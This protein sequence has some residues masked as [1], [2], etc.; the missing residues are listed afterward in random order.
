ME[1]FK[2]DSRIKAAFWT[3][4][5]TLVRVFA[6]FG[7]VRVVNRY[8]WPTHDGVFTVKSVH[9]CACQRSANV[10]SNKNRIIPSRPTTQFRQAK[11]APGHR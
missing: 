5:E 7:S 6:S 11:V 8:R 10:P 1:L 3:A 9:V 2:A 4:S